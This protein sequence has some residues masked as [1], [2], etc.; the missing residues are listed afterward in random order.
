MTFYGPSSD[1]YDEAIDPIL[2]SDWNHRSAF[3]DFYKE[4][5]VNGSSRP[6]MTSI[7]LNDAG[8]FGRESLKYSVLKTI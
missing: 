8:K 7:L 5:G 4:L 6:F 2:I 3:T 1:R